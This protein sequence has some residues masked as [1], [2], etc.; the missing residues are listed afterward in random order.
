MAMPKIYLET[1]MFN[2]LFVP[3]VPGYAEHKA[4]VKQV[5]DMIKAGRFEPFTSI[6]A[7]DEIDDT[8]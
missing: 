6:F 2:F 8:M 5:F 1:T 7:T 3:D 4:E